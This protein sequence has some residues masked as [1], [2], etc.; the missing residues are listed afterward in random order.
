MVHPIPSPCFFCGFI[1]LPFTD[2]SGSSTSLSSFIA[3]L[4]I[5]PILQLFR[6]AAT[7]SNI[8]HASYANSCSKWRRWP[9]PPRRLS[10]GPQA[11]MPR[12]TPFNASESY[13][14]GVMS[15][16]GSI[17]SSPLWQ[18]TAPRFRPLVSQYLLFTDQG[19]SSHPSEYF[20][21]T[22]QLHSWRNF[23]DEL[24]SSSRLAVRT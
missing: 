11:S 9:T 21:W 20:L 15:C 6:S 1:A 19:R 23:A 17:S 16:P 3:S 2:S 24:S 5:L 13:P 22:S 14:G 10:S 8:S 12:H 18:V 7:C 4:R